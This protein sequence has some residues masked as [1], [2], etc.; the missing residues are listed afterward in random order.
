[1]ATGF[2]PKEKKGQFI[3]RSRNGFSL[4]EVVVVLAIMIILTVV[5]VVNLRPTLSRKQLDTTAQTMEAVLD[6]ARSRAVSGE[7]GVVWGV[8]FD[9][10]TSTTPFYSLFQNSYSAANRINYYPLPYGVQFST[11]SIA[12]GGSLDVIFNQISGLPPASS[13]FV[14]NLVSGG[15][16]I[17]TSGI[18]ITSQGLVALGPIPVASSTVAGTV[19]T[20]ATT[21]ALTSAI[22]DHSA[23]VYNGYIYTTGGGDVNAN[24]TSTVLY[25]KLNGDGSISNWSNTTKLP[26]PL[27]AHSAVVNNGYIYT[28]GGYF[29]NLADDTSTVFYAKLNSTG[30]ISNWSSTTALPSISAGDSAVVNSG[31]I[32]ITSVGNTITS[33]VYYALFNSTGSI[34]NWSS[35]TALPSAVTLNSNVVYNGYIYTTG[36]KGLGSIYTSTVFYAPINSTGSVGAWGT[37][38]A[39]PSTLVLHSAV[40]YNG[41]IYTTGGATINGGGITSTVLYAKLNGDGTISSWSR[42]TLL[43]TTQYE[44][45]AIVN[46]GYIYITGGAIQN[47][48]STV[49]YAPLN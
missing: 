12:S 40:V 3:S 16:T 11:S 30:S 8:H 47:V 41:Y 29:D 25:A 27:Y 33:T 10:T 18:T 48:T 2:P 6:E 28:M 42:T 13:S 39:L 46:N 9:N 5:A 43:P 44:H 26:S 14:L 24:P 45:S 22:Y 15:L 49:W 23:V 1:M 32:Y 37:T 31:Y 17:A 20:W 19:G 38:A 7:S 35:T 36:G 34:S 21:T 4:I